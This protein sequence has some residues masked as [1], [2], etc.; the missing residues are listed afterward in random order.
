[1]KLR[2]LLL[3]GLPV[4]LL[5]L[6]AYAPAATL[7]GWLQPKDQPPAAELFGIEGTLVA[8]RVDGVVIG[9]RTVVADLH[10]QLRPLQLLLG[11][12]GWTLDAGKDPILFNGQASMSALGTLR[13]AD[14]RANAGL[15]ALLGSLGYFLPFDGQ[16]GLDFSRLV[17]RGRQL[18]QAEG[19]V[20]L[21]GLAWALGPNRTPLGD[22]RADVTTTDEGDVIAKLASVSG[23]L[24]LSGEARLKPDQSYDTHLQMKPKPGA[25]PMLQNMLTQMGAPDPQGYYHL[26]RQGS[27]APPQPAAP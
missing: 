3:T 15:P 2:S 25:P 21:Q 11:R 5:A 24:E 23:P 8:G 14:F 4:L 9:G 1:M 16:A 22:F 18:Q 13:L 20:Q 10:W 26:T 6:L 12:I 19:S 27:L 17:A 7:K